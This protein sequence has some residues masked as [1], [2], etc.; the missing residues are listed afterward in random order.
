MAETK[1]EKFDR[2]SNARLEKATK[3]IGV[4]GNLAS[5]NYEYSE[6]DVKNIL[7]TLQASISEI[8]EKFGISANE[9]ECVVEATPEVAQSAP[10]KPAE[11]TSIEKKGSGA[12]YD[13]TTLLSYANWAYDKLHVGKNKEAKELLYVGITRAKEKAKG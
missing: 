4:L 5:P 6:R 10:E 3:A 8:S 7:N 12:E 2:L 13:E 1:K 11:K 9:E